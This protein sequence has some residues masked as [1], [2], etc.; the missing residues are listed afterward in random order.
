MPTET[1][2]AMGMPTPL[3]PSL[4]SQRS[5]EAPAQT[6]EASDGWRPWRAGERESF[7]E[8]IARHRRAAWRVTLASG[9]ANFAVGLIVA[10]LMAPLFYAV[11]ALGFDIVNLIVPVPNLVEVLG[12]WFGPAIDAPESIPFS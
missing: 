10:L 8:A 12:R 1:G 2:S 5:A 7:F 6:R 3:A 11:I 9:G 4:V